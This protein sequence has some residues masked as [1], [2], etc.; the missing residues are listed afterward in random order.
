ME[1]TL[2]PYKVECFERVLDAFDE[3]EAENNYPPVTVMAFSIEEAKRKAERIV[4]DEINDYRRKGG[5]M[6]S[7]SFSA[8]TKRVS[9]EN[10]NILYQRND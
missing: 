9:D 1:G 7:G 2:K 3:E 4:Q 8:F 10:G 5:F 6:S